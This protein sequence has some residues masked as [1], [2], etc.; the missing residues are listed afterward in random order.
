MNKLCEDK[1]C[2][3]NLY[4]RKMCVRKLCVDKLCVRK[5]CV[6][7][8]CVDKWWRRGGGRREAGG[9]RRRGRDAEPKTSYPT[10][11]SGEQRTIAHGDFHH[12][13]PE[14]P[15]I[16][17]E[18]LWIGSSYPN[19]PHVVSKVTI[20]SEKTNPP[21]NQSN[22]IHVFIVWSITVFLFKILMRTHLTYAFQISISPGPGNLV[23]II[24]H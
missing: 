10:Q 17:A 5:L 2:V 19:S 4:V 24:N 12:S 16:F 1:L 18:L 7:K 20:K 6:D 8:L 23:A 11:R 9:G 21:S 15:W 22:N 14:H 13:Y 3:D